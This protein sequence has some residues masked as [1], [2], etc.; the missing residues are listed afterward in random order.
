MNSKTRQKYQQLVEVTKHKLLIPQGPPSRS[1]QITA[2]AATT[3]KKSN[4]RNNYEIAWFLKEKGVGVDGSE[5]M[6][7]WMMMTMIGMMAAV[8]VVWNIIVQL[9]M[10]RKYCFHDAWKRTPRE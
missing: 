5:L 8:V 4:L 1:F 7:V 6:L 10:G 9:Q 3:T 2:A